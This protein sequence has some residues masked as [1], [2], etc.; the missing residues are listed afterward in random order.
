VLEEVRSE[1]AVR[2]LRADGGLS[3][4]QLLM[5]LQADAIGIPVERMAVDSTARGAALL[6]GVGAGVF[7]ELGE[8]GSMLEVEGRVEPSRDDAWRSAEYERWKR[9]VTTASG[10]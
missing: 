2:S 7:A 4:D 9:F 1:I 6:A 5:Q 3:I 10:L 8:A